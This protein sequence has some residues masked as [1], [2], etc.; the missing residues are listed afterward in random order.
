MPLGDNYFLKFNFS[1]YQMKIPKN[2]WNLSLSDVSS[3]APVFLF[4]KEGTVIG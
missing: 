4:Q 3:Y 2:T 1:I